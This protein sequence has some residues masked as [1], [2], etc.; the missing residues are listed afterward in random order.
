MCNIVYFDQ[1]D[2]GTGQLLS[3]VYLQLLNSSKDFLAEISKQ[4]IETINEAFLS[5]LLLQIYFQKTSPYV[6]QKYTYRMSEKQL[7]CCANGRKSIH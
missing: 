6:L 7:K 4:I 1:H 3:S 2:V 5:T